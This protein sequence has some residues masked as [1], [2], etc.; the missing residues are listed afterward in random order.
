MALQQEVPSQRSAAEEASERFHQRAVSLPGVLRVESHTSQTTAEQTF[1]VYVRK[2]DLAA[3]NSVYDLE[4]ELY[5]LDPAARLD[6][7]VREDG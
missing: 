7:H 5:A 1:T 2:D 4:S 6:I 3:R